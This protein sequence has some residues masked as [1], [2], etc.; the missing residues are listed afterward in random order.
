M[1]AKAKQRQKIGSTNWLINTLI[2]KQFAVWF[3][4]ISITLKLAYNKNKPHKALGYWSS[5]I[6]HFYF[7]EKGLEIIFQ[8]HIVYYFSKKCFSCYIL[9]TDQISL[10][11]CLYFLSWLICV[12]HLFVNQAVTSWILK[13]ILSFYSSRFYTWPKSQEKNFNILRT[14]R[15]IKVK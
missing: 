11:D 2:S 9:L 14:K 4:Y 5:D 15:A 1:P 13:L 3:H 7:L 10:F 12:F 6:L 8:P